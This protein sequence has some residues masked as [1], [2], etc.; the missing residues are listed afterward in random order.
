MTQ[1][2]AAIKGLSVQQSK[3]LLEHTFAVEMRFTVP[4]KA[5][6]DLLSVIVAV[7]CVACGLSKS[8]LGLLGSLMEHHP[9]PIFSFLYFY[10]SLR[11]RELGSPDGAMQT[12]DYCLE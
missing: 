9:P 10:A 3:D 4:S 2:L 7:D 12:L 11:H 1:M 5:A 8:A 6:F